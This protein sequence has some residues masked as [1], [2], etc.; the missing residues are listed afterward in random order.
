MN[1]QID[2]SE[3]FFSANGRAARMPSL[4][5]AAALLVIAAFYEAVAEYGR[6]NRKFGGI[7]PEEVHE[8]SG[9]KALPNGVATPVS[10]DHASAK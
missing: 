5:A 3:V 7:L 4:I 8:Y 6:R 9:D 1:G 2:W 10:L